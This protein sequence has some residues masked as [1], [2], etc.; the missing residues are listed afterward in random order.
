MTDKPDPT[1]DV[2]VVTMANTKKDMLAAYQRALEVIKKQN[3]TLLKAEEARARAEEQAAL[4]TADA[5]T[6]E[7]PVR[8]LHELRT[9]VGRKF[10][11]IAES[12]EAEIATYMQVKKAAESKQEELRRLY[13]IEAAAADL[14]ALIEAQRN[15]KEE[16]EK[17]MAERREKLE[18]E[19]EARKKE[20]EAE[21]ETIRAAWENEQKRMQAEAAEK[22]AEI[23][24]ARKRDEEEYAYKIEREHAQ[25]RNAL[26]DEL[27]ALGKE[28]A[29]KREAFEKETAAKEA[30]LKQREGAVQAAE[31]ELAQLRKKVEAFPAE[32][33][34]AVAAAVQETTARLNTAFENKEALLKAQFEG[35]KNVLLSKI[36]AL[37]AQNA[38]Q[39]ALIKELAAKQDKAYEKIQDIANRA[40]EAARREIVALPLRQA[41]EDSERQPKR[42]N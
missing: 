4:A 28:I 36:E 37:E 7:D 42:A 29:A 38:G 10:S 22:R 25:R 16:F 5:Q 6:R 17:E 18:A 3:E 24:K 19:L 39:K 14:A 41:A 31:E 26:E 2:P 11:E 23:E 40:V 32:K 13:E 9:D 20:L 1:A 35:E 30:E 27:A 34:A 21:I 15:A 12:L 8:R 33:E